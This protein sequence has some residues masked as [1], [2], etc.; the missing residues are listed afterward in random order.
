MSFYNIKKWDVV[1]DPN[2]IT[3][4]PL[5]Y[6]EPDLAF[7]DAARLNN[8][9]LS[10]LFSNTQTPFFG[11]YDGLPIMG[12]VNTSCVIPNCRPNFCEKTNYYTITLDSRWLGYPINNGTVQFF[13]MKAV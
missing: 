3:Q 13:G 12:N 11:S 2:G 1:L 9:Q 8:M 7:L 5:I 6:I 10:C 4:V